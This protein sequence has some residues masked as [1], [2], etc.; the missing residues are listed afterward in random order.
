ME[1]KSDTEAFFDDRIQPLINEIYELCH[2]RGIYYCALFQI[3]ETEEDVH[4][5]S[6]AYCPPEACLPIRFPLMALAM[7][8]ERLKRFV[9]QFSLPSF[10]VKVVD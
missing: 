6:S 9:E 5:A 4:I 8:Y 2:E 3:G 10:P 1:K 7:D